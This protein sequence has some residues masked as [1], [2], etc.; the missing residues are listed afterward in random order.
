MLG[1]HAGGC[2]YLHR[3]RQ[4]VTSLKASPA[5]RAL[6]NVLYLYAPS[7]S[8]R[9]VSYLL[10]FIEGLEATSGYARMVHEEVFAS[11]LK[12]QLGVWQQG[13][14]LDDLAGVFLVTQSVCQVLLP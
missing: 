2:F 4:G 13:S 11:S 1:R 14:S 5:T 12:E 6:R 9:L 3:H 10:A 8:D 7:A